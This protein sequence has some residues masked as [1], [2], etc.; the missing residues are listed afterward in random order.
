MSFLSNDEL[1]TIL[2]EARNP[3]NI[4]TDIRKCFESI[5]S[6]KFDENNNHMIYGMHSTE[7]E[8]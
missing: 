1:L 8:S 3:I 5:N 4:Q 6:L 2:A 7:P